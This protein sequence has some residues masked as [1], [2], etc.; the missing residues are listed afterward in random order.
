[1][2][3]LVRDCKQQF[4]MKGFFIRTKTECNRFDP[5]QLV[6]QAPD[7]KNYTITAQV[8]QVVAGQ[9]LGL[10]FVP[11]D[12]PD[13]VELYELCQPA[14]SDEVA[15]DDPKVYEPGQHREADS[16]NISDQIESMSVAE[17]RQA[18]LHGRKSMRMMLIKH[19][20]KTLH[21]FVIR[22]PAITLDEVQQIARMPSVNPD[23]LRSIAKNKDWSR[24][25]TVCRNLVRNP[26]TPMKEALQL[27]AKLPIS[28]VRA[29]A[30][31]PH[32]RTPIQQAA[33]KKIGL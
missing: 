2:A 32:V 16:Q 12:Q 5:V 18:A 19:R 10:A 28:E 4:E 26:K 8:V 6:I 27:L 30:K 23:V 9:G 20:N 3:A 22:N 29:L 25:T 17:L 13:L 21:P 11:D 24:S 7:K 31:S 14:P 1:M 15:A 33:R